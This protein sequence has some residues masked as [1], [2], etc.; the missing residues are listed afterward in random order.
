MTRFRDRSEAGRLL[1]ECLL[2]YRD[3]APIVLALPRGGV[4]VG[5]EISRALEAPLDVFVV[6]KLGAPDQ[7]ELGIGAVA[8][9][10]TRV[11][12]ERILKHLEVSEEYLE[13]V[14]WRERAEVERRLKLLRGE[15]PIPEMRDRTLIL[16]DDGLA[17]GVTAL[18]AIAAIREYGPLRIV[19]AL[20]VCAAQTAE[21]I[22]REVDDIV[23]LETPSD[24]QAIGLW[25][26]DFGQV[27]DD[28][29]VSLLNAARQE[30]A[31][32]SRIK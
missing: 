2:R 12:N 8:Q 29:V 30:Q 6:R 11:L 18:A 1:G 31:F 15:F 5:L 23:S 17:T 3:L 4:P 13:R 9:G 25:Y 28:E 21:V 19:L 27:L 16:V 10:G 22:G 32:R 26:E 14:T 7:A 20:P 24:L